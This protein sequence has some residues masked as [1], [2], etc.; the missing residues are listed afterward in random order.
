VPKKK[1]RISL[2][3]PIYYELH[4]SLNEASERKGIFS[5]LD[6]DIAVAIK[7]GMKMYK[8]Y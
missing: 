5:G 6:E 3:V 2:T 8:K 4:D 1:P 7:E